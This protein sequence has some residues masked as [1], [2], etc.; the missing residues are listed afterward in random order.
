MIRTNIIFNAL[1]SVTIYC[2]GDVHHMLIISSVTN[3]HSVSLFVQ[4][5]IKRHTPKAFR[6]EFYV[7]QC[8]REQW[9]VTRHLLFVLT[10][11]PV[12]I[13]ERAQFNAMGTCSLAYTATCA[14]S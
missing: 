8:V 12:H 1:S 3:F 13:I 7:Y 11:C 9:Q 2:S 6:C 14:L 10:A 4:I 5:S